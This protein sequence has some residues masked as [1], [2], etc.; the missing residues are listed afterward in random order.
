MLATRPLPHTITPALLALT[1]G[2]VLLVETQL[3]RHRVG[4]MCAVC[5]LVRRVLVHC[6]CWCTVCVG[7]LCVCVCVLVCWCVCW[8]T[9]CVGALCVLVH[10]VLVHC[11]C[12]C[13]CAGVCEGVCVCV[14]VCSR[15]WDGDDDIDQLQL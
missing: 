4:I 8:C 3:L 15:A 10:C 13:W 2:I 12:V 9:V 5:V 1:L 7:A 6:V 14:C 11:V